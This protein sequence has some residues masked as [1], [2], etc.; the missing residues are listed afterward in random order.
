[1]KWKTTLVLLLLTVGTGA[2]VSLYELK[3]PSPERRLQLSKEVVRVN[4]EDVTRLLVAFPQASATFEHG[5]N[6]WTLLGPRTLRAEDS[7]ISQAL[8]QLSPLESEHVL[9]P[10][11]ERPLKLEDYG[12]DPPR[13]AL[14]ILT[15]RGATKLLFGDPTAVGANRYVA[16][17]GSPNVFVASA[18]LFDALNQPLEA[19]RSHELITLNAGEVTRLAVTSSTSSYT[20]TRTGGTS[21][22]AP[23]ADRWRL[24]HPVDDAAEGSAVAALLSQ[25]QG[26]RAERFIADL[27]A[28][29]LTGQAGEAAATD[30]GRWG[31]EAPYATITLV[32]K[33]DQPPFELLIGKVTED[34]DQQR[35]AKRSD[36]PTV[37]AVVN[38]KIEEWLRDPQGLRSLA[39]F[40][41]FASQVQKLQ[42]TWEGISWTVEQQ[43]DQWT[44][45]DGMPLDGAAVEEFLWKVRDLKLTRFLEE[46][47]QDLARY[48]LAPAQGMIQVWLT[49]ES[50]PQALSVGSAVESG[51]TRYGLVE[52]RRAVVELPETINEIVATPSTS[53]TPQPAPPAE[54]DQ[55]GAPTDTP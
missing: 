30:Q 24:M 45:A 2:Y 35:Y 32:T 44:A 46:Q 51:T 55:P 49:G 38:S 27:P 43:D 23:Q 54:S 12:L 28:S 34:N 20:L 6:T 1:M 13:A 29:N 40:E 16:V 47:P 41:F 48:G 5:A 39:C 26:L 50:N 33:E 4:P 8:N 10:T 31:L 3:Q 42:L 36:E 19:F 21:S 7:L 17:E 18:S 37:S 52:G 22:P 25:L 53:F 11:P 15:A 9:S 14:T